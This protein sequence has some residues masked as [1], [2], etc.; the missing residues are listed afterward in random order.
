MPQKMCAVCISYMKHAIMF[1]QQ[2]INNSNFMKNGASHS[3][4]NNNPAAAAYNRGR[5]F[6]AEPLD[7]DVD[8]DHEIDNALLAEETFDDLKH[9]L[10][11]AF[12]GPGDSSDD[13]DDDEGDDPTVLFSYTEKRFTEDDILDVGDQC[14]GKIFISEP[15]QIRER[16]CDA[17]RKRFMLKDTFEQHLKECIELK[18][19]KFITDSYQLL[20]IR[21]ARSLSAHE[22]VRRVIFAL[23]KLVKSLAIYYKGV[24]DVPTPFQPIVDDVK[25]VLLKSTKTIDANTNDRYNFVSIKDN[26]NNATEIAN[27]SDGVPNKNSF[28]LLKGKANILIKK[29]PIERELFVRS[30]EINKSSFPNAKK[31]HDSKNFLRHLMPS[32]QNARIYQS[33]PIETIV[34]QCSPCSE[35]FTSLALFEEHNRQFHNMTRLSP[36]TISTASSTPPELNVPIIRAASN[37]ADTL[38]ADERNTL[39]ERLAS[40][41]IQF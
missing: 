33:S 9:E 17:C 24:I 28:N 39:L 41:S 32:V 10:D 3:V 15:A 35:S 1:R 37:A 19:L 23:K 38:N 20:T 8:F 2:V 16:K 36:S 21:K 12:G 34:A 26:W 13:D 31:S 40:R 29:N 30:D 18:L 22:F 14:G 27:A 5:Y 6:N 11:L 25:N 7:D 4:L